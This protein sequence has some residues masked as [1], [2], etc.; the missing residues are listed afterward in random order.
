MQT[1]TGL[2]VLRILSWRPLESSA[3]WTVHREQEADVYLVYGF[4]D[5]N[6]RVT[7][8]VVASG[9]ELSAPVL[10]RR[11]AWRVS[12]PSWAR[13]MLRKSPSQSEGKFSANF[14]SNWLA[15]KAGMVSF[16][17]GTSLL[18]HNSWVAK[19]WNPISAKL[20]YISV[21]DDEKTTD[22][23]IRIVLWWGR[24]YSKFDKEYDQWGEMKAIE[25]E[26]KWS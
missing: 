14:S 16:V 2:W 21:G 17:L 26:G 24:L 7:S 22:C 5:G 18:K 11:R 12:T 9:T 25:C 4:C 23:K 6:V 19:N 13:R 15:A 8:A 20:Q 1:P 3:S 10:A